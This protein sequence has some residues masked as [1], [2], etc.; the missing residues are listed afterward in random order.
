MA[1][2]ERHACKKRPYATRDDVMDCQKST[3]RQSPFCV[4]RLS[5][6]SCLAHRLRKHRQVMDGVDGRKA[7]EH[8]RRDASSWTEGTITPRAEQAGA[9]TKNSVVA[10]CERKV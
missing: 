6:I 5:F 3:S 4:L 8:Q 7:A 10:A 9:D 2:A 1:F